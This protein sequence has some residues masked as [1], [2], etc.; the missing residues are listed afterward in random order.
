M[1]VLRRGV[2]LGMAQVLAISLNRAGVPLDGDALGRTLR[3]AAKV[4]SETA[5]LDVTLG[6]REPATVLAEAD[7]ELQRC[8]ALCYV[9]TTQTGTDGP[10]SSSPM[11]PVTVS[12]S[13]YH[14]G[15]VC[16]VKPVFDRADGPAHRRP[17]CRP[18][19]P[20]RRRA[21]QGSPRMS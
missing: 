6:L 5:L 9:G 19:W 3:D 11:N 18:A 16:T 7:G 17:C 20:A 21:A 1:D 2:S 4:P 12:V 8:Q 13:R 10:T 14:D 15:C